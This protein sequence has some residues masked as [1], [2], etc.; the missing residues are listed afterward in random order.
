MKHRCKIFRKGKKQ[1]GITLV[2]L[3]VTVVVLL[4]LAGVSIRLV[5]DN[6][7]I[8]KKAGEARD[9]HEQG[10]VNDQ[11]DLDS[12]SDYLDEITGNLPSKK[13]ETEPYFPGDG[14]SRVSGTNLS[15]GLVIED[16]SGNQYVWIEVPKTTT[17]YPTAGTAITEFTDD[18]YTAI[19]TDLHTYTN[20]Y[21]DGTSYKDE[22]YSDA[23]TGLT[24]SQYSAL[25]KKMLRSVY[26]HGGF[27]I[28]RYEAG[29]E[30]NRTSHSAI[31]KDFVPA[32]KPNQ[33]PLSY[34]TCREAQTLASRILPSGGAYTGSLMFG[35][36]WDLVL[37]Y[38]ET[39]G[40][41]QADLKTDS[42]SWGN[43]YNSS[44]IINRGRYAKYLETNGTWNE[45]NITLKNLI[46]YAEGVSK[47]MSANLYSD[48]ILL[49][50]G[51]SETC[52]NQNIYDL[53]GNVYELT[54][55]YGSRTSGYPCTERGGYCSLNGSKSPASCRACVATTDNYVAIGARVSIF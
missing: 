55:E 17:V 20:V 24:S 8:I 21:R 50:T 35:V 52:K 44:F 2:A 9:K 40:T 33:Y 23:T 46:T 38:L 48:G 42:T 3:V 43:Y 31:T 25:K 10:R 27:W 47:K 18:E 15:N 5:L 14:F 32:S 53:A 11:T 37:K 13:G 34:I 41:S 7:G 45:Y 36:Q 49:T 22:Y 51:A 16:G 1:A 54:L 26:Q 30:E 6:N 29:I 19:E 12:V 28:G 39:K 4:I